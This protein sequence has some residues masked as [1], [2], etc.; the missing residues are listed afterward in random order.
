M[1]AADGELLDQYFVDLTPGGSIQELE[2]FADRGGRPD[3][4][5]GYVTVDVISGSGV[6]VSASV[7]DSQSNDATTVYPKR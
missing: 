6:M 4:G 3:L 1:F 5:W 2:P 7:I